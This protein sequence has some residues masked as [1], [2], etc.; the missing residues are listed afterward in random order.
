M[1][2]VIDLMLKSMDVVEGVRN[3]ILRGKKKKRRDGRRCF[4]GG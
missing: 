1:L 4:S 2:E 3:S